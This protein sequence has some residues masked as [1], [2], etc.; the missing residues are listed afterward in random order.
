MQH[1]T[2]PSHT[3]TCYNNIRTLIRVHICTGHENHENKWKFSILKSSPRLCFKKNGQE[4]STLKL[5]N[6]LFP[7][8]DF[9]ENC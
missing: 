6:P 1:H 4:L 7:A 5:L 2:I 9:Y 3:M 8:Y